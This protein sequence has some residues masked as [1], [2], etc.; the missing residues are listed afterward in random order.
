MRNRARLA[1]TAYITIAL[2]LAGF[3]ASA[4]AEPSDGGGDSSGDETVEVFNYSAR[5]VRAD[6]QEEAD[7]ILGNID[8]TSPD[9]TPKPQ[10]RKGVKG[11]KYGPC[12]LEV[13][14]IYLRKSFQYNSVGFKSYTRCSGTKVTSIRHD[15]RFK[16]K[17]GLYW[18]NVVPTTGTSNINRGEA[19]LG[20]EKTSFLCTSKKHDYWWSGLTRGKIV[21]KGES[22]FVA[23]AAPT[24]KSKIPCAS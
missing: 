20:S 12:K 10:L 16:H 7:E 22:Y 8:S 19:A 3:S 1:A 13:Q 24:S 14:G 17:D 23:V 9:G 21:Y 18:K 15:M 4:N 6:S 2:C 5:Y 11:V